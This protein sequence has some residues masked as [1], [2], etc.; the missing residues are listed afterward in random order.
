M[1]N[2]ES[3]NHILNDFF[4]IELISTTSIHL[5]IRVMPTFLMP[6]LSKL[7]ERLRRQEFQ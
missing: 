5:K 2:I 4:E 3:L 6:Q 7:G 1:I